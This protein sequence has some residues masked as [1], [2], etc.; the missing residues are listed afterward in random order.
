MPSG[1][2]LSARSS[3]LLQYFMLSM[4]MK[5][6][7][8]S[9]QNCLSVLHD[10]NFVKRLDRSD[11]FYT[12]KIKR[13]RDDAA[14]T[15]MQEPNSSLHTSFMPRYIFPGKS[16]RRS[17][18]QH[19]SSTQQFDRFLA[20]CPRSSTLSALQ[21]PRRLLERQHGHT[22]TYGTNSGCTGGSGRLNCVVVHIGVMQ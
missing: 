18:K 20:N 19:A 1:Y 4:R 11:G 15:M 8:L 14:L 22:K 16:G 5:L 13:P 3:I 10:G 17:A 12:K 6:H 2:G 7:L 9:Q 21:K